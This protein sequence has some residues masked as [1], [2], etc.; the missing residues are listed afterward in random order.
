M[1]LILLLSEDVPVSYRSFALIVSKS[2]IGLQKN[3]RRQVPTY[4]NNKKT[5]I[6]RLF[7]ISV[8]A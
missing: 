2:T 3:R 6:T 4:F 8:V 1:K 5:G 7:N